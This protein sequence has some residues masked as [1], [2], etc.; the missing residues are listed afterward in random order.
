MGNYPL[1]YDDSE[2]TRL[3]EQAQL[4]HDPGLAHA[5]RGRSSCLEIGCGNG[6]NVPVIAEAN[7][8]LRY[9]GLDVSPEALA[10]ARASFPEKE[11][12]I[13]D[14]LEL[15]SADV[16]TFDVVVCRLLLWSLG[17]QAGR[18][19]EAASQVMAPD[20]VLYLYEPDDG[21][22][23]LTPRSGETP[24]AA[25]RLIKQWQAVACERG[26]DPFIG[27]RLPGLLADTDLALEACQ[28]DMRCHTHADRP[29]LTKAL[30]NLKGIF[31][32]PGAAAIGLSSTD[33]GWSRGASQMDDPDYWEVVTEAY[34]SI[35][36][37]KRGECK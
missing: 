3:A 23:T 1:F 12:R 28:V 37:R 18:V 26:H 8:G 22:L 32:K 6:A 14:A 11:F 29:N 9:V 30:A 27:R 15:R 24:T 17:A 21:H 13:G 31:V 2:A 10:E 20:G 35:T 4:L 33:P 16:G 5:V 7:P 36:A 34:Y 19:L 25:E